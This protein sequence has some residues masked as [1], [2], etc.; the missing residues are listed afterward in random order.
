M[1]DA[2]THTR[3][4][5]DAWSIE[6]AVAEIR[7]THP[8]ADLEVVPGDL[9]LQSSVRDAAADVRS[10]R[11]SPPRSPPRLPGT[12]PSGGSARGWCGSWA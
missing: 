11:R 7:R 10:E 8:D 12:R 9:S 1:F 4:Y 5:K 2:L 3:H 6:D